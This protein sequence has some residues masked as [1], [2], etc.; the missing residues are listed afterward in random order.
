[1]LF[2]PTPYIDFTP[3]KLTEGK[4]WFI[5]FYVRNPASGAMK[6]I[7]IKVNRIKNIRQRRQAARQ[8]MSTLQ[9]KLSLGWNPLYCVS[10]RQ[11][12]ESLMAVLD[13]F[14]RTKHKEME[15]Q[16]YR[17]YDSFVRVFRTWCGSIG[18]S[19]EAPVSVFT[20]DL[21]REYLSHID[22]TEGVS[23]RTYNNYLSFQCTLWEWMKEK[24]YA[25]D[26]VFRGFKKKPRRLMTKGRRL[27]TDEEVTRLIGWLRREN[28][29]FLAVVLLCYSCFIRPK[30]IALLRCE[31]ID[32][33][34]QTVRV[35]A[36]NAKNDKESWR[37]IPDSVMP[38]FRKLDLSC[39]ELF[40]FGRHNGN[41]VNF[42]P[43]SNPISEK[44]FS[45]YWIHY[46]RPACGFG[47]DVKLYSLKDTG[48]TGMLGRGVPI[49]LVQQQADHS[50]VAM[51]AIY[52]GKTATV[53]EPIK[54]L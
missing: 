18:I 24:G 10:V 36:E 40:V 28:P 45:D 9:A 23:A 37:T 54:D 44:K 30:E 13:V 39:R 2:K 19:N 7:R 43:G 25:P 14:L 21:A 11:S 17:S 33:E 46:V 41:A 26:N 5:S 38:D 42:K 32:L 31:D 4:E 50:S 27:L 52:V 51:T 6:R 34:R 29:E 53:S 20:K 49:N 22:G 1:M 15:K 48:I 12:G 8:M 35:R 16:S 47:V 3:P